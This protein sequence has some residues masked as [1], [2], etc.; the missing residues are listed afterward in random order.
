[1]KIIEFDS[2][3]GKLLVE[4][5]DNSPKSID[6]RTNVSLVNDIIDKTGKNIG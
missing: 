5:E 3:F 1:M 2:S 4:I 6:G